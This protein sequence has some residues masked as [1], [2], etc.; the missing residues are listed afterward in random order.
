[1]RIVVRPARGGR[2]KV[3]LAVHSAG[4]GRISLQRW[5]SSAAVYLAQADALVI[6]AYAKRRLADEYDAAQ[7]RDEVAGPLGGGERSGRER[8]PTAATVADFG[9]TPKPWA[10]KRRAATRQPWPEPL[11]GKAFRRHEWVQTL[12]F[13]GKRQ[14]RSIL[15]VWTNDLNADRK[16]VD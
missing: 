8:S 11:S 7:E 15:Q 16:P 14:G 6:E 9:L 10:S 13:G 5:P 2:R 3:G 1:M 4:S 12:E